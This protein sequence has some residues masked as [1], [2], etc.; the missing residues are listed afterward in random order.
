MCINIYPPIDLSLVQDINDPERVSSYVLATLDNSWEIQDN[1]FLLTLSDHWKERRRVYRA[2]LIQKCLKLVELDH[3][4]VDPG[5]R[6]E[7]D[8]I[9]RD[10]RN[11]HTPQS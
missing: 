1:E 10:F 4:R 5:D 6:S 3:I 8:L 11:Y 7:A 9:I 2:L